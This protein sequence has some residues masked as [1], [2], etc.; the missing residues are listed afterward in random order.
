MVT[1]KT[2]YFLFLSLI[3]VS[4]LPA[5]AAFPIPKAPD[6]PDVAPEPVVPDTPSVPASGPSPE[7]GS[8]PEG[9]SPNEPNP[10]GPPATV[11]GEYPGEDPESEASDI[12]EHLSDILDAITSLASLA[13]VGTTAAAT[14]IT[15]APSIPTAAYP[16]SS[17]E[18]IYNSCS[19]QHPDFN[20]SP[21]SAQA[22]CLCYAGQSNYATAWAPSIFDGYISSCNSYV[23][24]QTQL[25]TLQGVGGDL[26]LCSSAGQFIATTGAVASAS[27]RTGSPS[28]P[29]AASAPTVQPPT[30]AMA[31]QCGIKWPLTFLVGIIC[32]VLAL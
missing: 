14:T 8:K 32:S 31:S 27:T 24:A 6:A 16:C 21:Q 5:H 2:R 10:I 9:T 7:S 18:V 19:S 22:R 26:G 17:A 1:Q 11:P 28:I 20:V 30:M 3:L 4:A 15:S 12:G 13:V 23:Q 25:S 29:A